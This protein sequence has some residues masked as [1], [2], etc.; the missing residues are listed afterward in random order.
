M[1]KWNEM[2]VWRSNLSQAGNN[3]DEFYNGESSVIQHH[4]QNYYTIIQPT[5]DVAMP[6]VKLGF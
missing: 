2:G 3:E 6:E 5:M 4:T 1:K